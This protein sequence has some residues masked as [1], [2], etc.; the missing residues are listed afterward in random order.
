MSAPNW[1]KN[2]LG[3]GKLWQGSAGRSSRRDYEREYQKYRQ[4]GRDALAASRNTEAIEAFGRA[5]LFHAKDSE[6]HFNLGQALQSAGR[7]EAARQAYVRALN[8]N[9]A[10]PEVRRVLLS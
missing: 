3:S 8:V 1:L 2:L 10:S 4:K 5:A 9:P 7:I 6:A